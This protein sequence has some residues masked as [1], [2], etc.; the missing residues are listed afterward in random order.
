MDKLTAMQTFVRIVETGSLTAAANA[1]DTSLPT[2]V[3]ALAALERQ[4]GVSLLHRTTRRMHLTDEGARYLERCRTILSAVQDTEEH[5]RSGRSEAVGKL[6]VT[7]S[8]LFGRRYIA[9]I[10][11]DF[12]RRHPQV[13]A[14]LLFVDRVV[15]LIEEG[16]D[17]AVRIG[18]LKDSSL[19]ATAVGRVRPVVCAS[20]QYLRRH[21]TPQTPDD[22]R[23]H[24]CIRHLGLV[25]RGEWPFRVGTRQ[26]SIPITSV[27]TCNE[28]DTAVN[29]CVDGLGLGLFLSYMVAPN[30][31]AG[32]LKYV[33]EK[34]ETE[35]MPVHVVYPPSKLVSAKVR[36]FIDDCVAQLRRAKFD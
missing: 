23:K 10:V 21:G 32:Q 16:V 28:I 35:P 34:F 24:A 17:V 5:L 20:E 26:V 18:H 33:L 11:N 7:A 9:G 2:V 22:L 36:A 6:T 31:K 14:D 4:L 13:S 8:V 29:A 1:L 3:R 25:P 27:V 19:V 12:L 15:N 30:T